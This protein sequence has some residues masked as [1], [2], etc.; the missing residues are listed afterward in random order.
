MAWNDCDHSRNIFFCE[1][2]AKSR[3]LLGGKHLGQCFRDAPLLQHLF[4]SLRAAHED[5]PW[6]FGKTA[7]LVSLAAAHQP[8]HKFL[9]VNISCDV[10]AMDWRSR[11]AMVLPICSM[12]NFKSTCPCKILMGL[13][14][15]PDRE[16]CKGI[17]GSVSQCAP[18]F[19]YSAAR[20]KGWSL[21]ARFGLS[22]RNL[23]YRSAHVTSTR[24]M[25]ADRSSRRIPVLNSGKLVGMSGRG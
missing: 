14:D 11:T 12:S 7:N 22:S 5:R 9:F 6:Q 21:I 4:Q 17:P 25:S 20:K 13:P 2:S 16:T 19:S 3:R 24:S 15:S 8:A 18:P 1:E 10:D 23:L